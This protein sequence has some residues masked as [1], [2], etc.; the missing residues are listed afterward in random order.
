MPTY[1]GDRRHDSE[2]VSIV[3]ACT[4]CLVNIHLPCYSL[5]LRHLPIRP[6][7]F[8]IAV[9]GHHDRGNG[10]KKAFD[11]GIMVSDG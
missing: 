4:R 11:L 8:S 6:S 2:Y 3:T 5:Q 7:D 9:K 10:S 1:C